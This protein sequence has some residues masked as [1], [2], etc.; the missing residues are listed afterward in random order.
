MIIRKGHS[1]AE[2]LRKDTPPDP[3]PTLLYL[4]H[5]K[6]LTSEPFSSKILFSGFWL[7]FATWEYQQ[8]NG[9]GEE[10]SSYSFS[11]GLPVGSFWAGWVP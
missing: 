5:P 11:W 3:L 7:C 2:E 9:K 6:R 8:K 1:T 4:I 10:G